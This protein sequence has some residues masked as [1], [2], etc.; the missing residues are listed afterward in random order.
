MCD[1]DIT[2]LDGKGDDRVKIGKVDEAVKTKQVNRNGF[3][4]TMVKRALPRTHTPNEIVAQI[5]LSLG[6]AQE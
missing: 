1:S 4:Q 6:V 2:I 3:F 5:R